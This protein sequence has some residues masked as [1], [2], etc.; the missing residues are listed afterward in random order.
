MTDKKQFGAIAANDTNDIIYNG[1]KPCYM[2]GIR[3]P[4]MPKPNDC[5]SNPLDE[6]KNTR[7]KSAAW[8]EAC[9]N[10]EMAVNNKN[11]TFPVKNFDMGKLAFVAGLWRIQQDFKQ[12]ITRVRDKDMVLMDKLDHVE[13]TLFEFWNAKEI[14]YNC[15]GVFL[16][17]GNKPDYIVAKYDTDKETYLGYGRTL[18]EA[19]AFLGLKMYDEYKDV[20]NAIA[21]ANKLKNKTK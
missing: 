10:N 6:Y 20:I 21:C 11:E 2:G 17:L 7:E 19:R 5:W 14:A 3:V 15:Y 13:N 8:N 1:G 18:E 9:R 4:Y 12:K 16:S